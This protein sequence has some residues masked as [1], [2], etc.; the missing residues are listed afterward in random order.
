MEVTF[1]TLI[2]KDLQK[3][4]E[5][6]ALQKA[7]SA[8]DYAAMETLLKQT[9]RSRKVL[10][11]S[12]D[13]CSRAIAGGCPR[14]VFLRLLQYCKPLEEVETCA[15]E[16]SSGLFPYTKEEGGLVQQ[17]A[18]HN[19]AAV[20]EYLL[21]Q[22][23]SPNARREGAISPLEMA[24]QA[25]AKDVL[26]L[27]RKRTDTDFTVTER[28][29]DIWGS[30]GMNPETDACLCIVAGRLLGEGAE[31]EYE[32][33]PQLPGLN[34]HH[35]AKQKN[36]LLVHRLCGEDKMGE[37]ERRRLLEMDVRFH[38]DSDVSENV[39]QINT[40]LTICP[41]FLRREIPRFQLADCLLRGEEKEVELLRPWLERMPG[42][43]VTLY[44]RWLPEGEKDITAY[45]HR[46][47][48]RMGPRFRPA[49]DRRRV[50]P[51]PFSF[52]ANCD[53]QI[54][55]LLR[56][57]TVRGKPP[58][59]KVSRLATNVLQMASPEL[60]GQLLEEGTLFLQED[61]ESLL[62]FCASM[63]DSRRKE[64]LFLL[65]IYCQKKVDYS[66]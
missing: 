25:R 56:C 58:R 57:C 18:M 30:M 20:L 64:K 44:G 33:V 7:L 26:Q 19:N 43:L 11:N 27:L 4:K 29:L 53:D 23:F 39:R 15:V 31:R 47:E 54:R 9:G 32:E 41:E 34:T 60:L 59:D 38:T 6:Q 16:R 62:R 49:L 13:L 42:R 63:G 24:L 35:A 46:W 52:H 2:E 50:L 22:G 12:Y 28:I 51:L 21:E 45:L 48:E 17:A 5:F 55:I 8:G 14:E 66:L 40:L 61:R 10:A 36:W 37:T 65:Q 3:E 1:R